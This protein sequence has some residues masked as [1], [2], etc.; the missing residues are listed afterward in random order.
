MAK[1][2]QFV[3]IHFCQAWWFSATHWLHPKESLCL[4]RVNILKVMTF[5][6]TGA[7]SQ[8]LLLLTSSTD[9]YPRDYGRRFCTRPKWPYSI[10]LMT[11]TSSFRITLGMRKWIP[12][13]MLRFHS[14]FTH[15]YMWIRALALNFRFHLEATQLFQAFWSLTPCSR[16]TSSL[17]F[18]KPRW[19]F[20]R[21]GLLDWGHYFFLISSVASE[22]CHYLFLGLFPKHSLNENAIQKY[23]LEF[24]YL[25]NDFNDLIG[26]DASKYSN[27]TAIAQCSSLNG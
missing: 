7:R 21:P 20:C 10:N 25:L 4:L 9:R 5:S 22:W 3:K 27:F 12:N 8:Y 18:L 26:T 11:Y 2:N 17:L 15:L 19:A 24:L 6:R 1:R 14:V 13:E 23:Y 16:W